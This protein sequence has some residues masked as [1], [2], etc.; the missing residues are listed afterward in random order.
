MMS[1]T[2]PLCGAEK[3]LGLISSEK[4]YIID[5]LGCLHHIVTRL[6][7]TKFCLQV[8]KVALKFVKRAKN[9]QILNKSFKEKA[10]KDNLKN[11]F[12]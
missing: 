3:N 4:A 7:K 5:M 9:W 10:T 1:H 8:K 11:Y 2:R 6:N 12:F